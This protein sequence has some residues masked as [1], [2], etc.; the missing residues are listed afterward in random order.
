FFPIL[1]FLR[2]IF[3]LIMPRKSN[4]KVPTRTNKPIIF[5]ETKPSFSLSSPTN[6]PSPPP[7]ISSP[8]PFLKPPVVS[9]ESHSE[10]INYCWI[11]TKRTRESHVERKPKP[12][13]LGDL[14]KLERKKIL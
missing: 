3:L 13:I 1:K 8:P 10:V 2:V 11:G 12:E 14:D 4:K 7:F 6:S 9:N 5:S